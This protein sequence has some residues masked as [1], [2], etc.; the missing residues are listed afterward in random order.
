MA[1]LT[2]LID[3]E[4]FQAYA[5]YAAVVLLKMMMMSPI[6]TYFRV[7]RKVRNWEYC[8]VEQ[9]EICI[10]KQKYHVFLFFSA[11]RY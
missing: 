3:N 5:T 6:T 9:I 2:Q 11:F 8:L 1:K 7:R 4:V 10:E